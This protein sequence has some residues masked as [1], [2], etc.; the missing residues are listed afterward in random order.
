MTMD[1]SVVSAKSLWSLAYLIVVGGSLKFHDSSHENDNAARKT[2]HITIGGN[3]LQPLH[4]KGE[5]DAKR[6]ETSYLVV[7]PIF[8]GTIC[9]FG[10]TSSRPASV[11]NLPTST[12]FLLSC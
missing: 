11:I 1:W 7:E 10:L 3:Y 2:R 5:V 8:G 6:P 12:P 9:Q 4:G